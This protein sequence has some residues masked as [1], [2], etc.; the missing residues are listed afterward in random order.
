[1]SDIGD[2]LIYLRQHANRDGFASA[3]TAELEKYATALCHSQAF[4]HFGEREYPQ[5]CETVRVHLLRAHIAAL[6]NHIT[7][8]DAK[9]TTLSWLVIALT[10]ASLFGAG[11]QIWFAY[12]ADKRAEQTTPPVV[13]PQQTPPIAPVLPFHPTLQVP[14]KPTKKTP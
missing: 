11:S 7:A 10:V 5:L 1:M 3:S 13:T 8:L 6:H 9:N 12:K 2:T 14:N 4:T